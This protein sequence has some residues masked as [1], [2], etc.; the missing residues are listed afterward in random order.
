MEFARSRTG[1]TDAIADLAVENFVEMRDLVAQP[2]FQL[3]K[4]VE[5]ILQ[6]Q[7]PE[8]FVP[9]YSMVT[10]HRVP[11]STARKRGMIQDEILETVCS[12]ITSPQDVDLKRAGTLIQN[13]LSP[14][15]V[16][17]PAKSDHP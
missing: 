14:L 4:K 13:R 17:T 9:K 5:Q 11:Y 8:R 2:S 15:Y 3:K 6:K 16:R 10:F 7:F 12:S 1:D